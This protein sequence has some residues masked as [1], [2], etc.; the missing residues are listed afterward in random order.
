MRADVAIVLINWQRPHEVAETIRSIVSQT[1]RSILVYVVNNGDPFALQCALSPS[2]GIPVAVIETGRNTG[3]SGAC[4]LA[5]DRAL[6]DQVDFLW[7]LNTD[8][9]LTPTCLSVLISD[10]ENNCQAGLFSPIVRNDEAGYPVWVAGGQFNEKRASFNWFTS[11]ADGIAC[12][13]ESPDQL[14]LPGTALLVRRQAFE[15]IGP[16]DERLFAYHEDV[17]FSIRA[18]KLGIGRRLVADAELFHHHRVGDKPAPHVGYYTVRNALL[19]ARKYS[20]I[21]TVLQQAYWEFNRLRRVCAHSSRDITLY[22]SRVLGFWHGLIGRGGEM[23]AA[24]EPP[25]WLS[26]LLDGK[27]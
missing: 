27:R 6:V 20:S 4:N 26:K 24:T 16:M 11:E 5:L 25:R 1:H 23:T 10:A 8:T 18:N 19:L 21:I 9:R 13:M 12:A 14:M 2:V 17:D 3:F 22:N 15:Q 7:F